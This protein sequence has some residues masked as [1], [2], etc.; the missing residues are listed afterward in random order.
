MALT[1]PYPSMNFV[2]LDVLTAAE[3]NQLVANIEYIANQFPITNANI[4]SQAVKS[5]NID[6]GTINTTLEGLSFTKYRFVYGGDCNNMTTP[7]FYGFY[8]I[9]AHNPGNGIYFAM[10]VF[11]Y[12]GDRLGQ[13]AFCMDDNSGFYIKARVLYYNPDIGDAEWTTWKTISMS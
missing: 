11:L 7:G 10:A 5:D 13:L 8:H 6:W 12:T 3:Q 2:P 1:L 4:A 9:T